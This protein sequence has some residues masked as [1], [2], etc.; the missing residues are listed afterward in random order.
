MVVGTLRGGN[1]G[2]AAKTAPIYTYFDWKTLSYQYGDFES[3]EPEC[4]SCKETHPKEDLDERGR[5]SKTL[6]RRKAIYAELFWDKYL[7]SGSL[8]YDNS[9]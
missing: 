9:H 3:S 1:W 8:P 7:S 2:K 6:E 5:C 4:P